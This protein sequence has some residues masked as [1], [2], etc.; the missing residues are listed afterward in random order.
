MSE[1]HALLADTAD[2]VLAGLSGEFAADWRA[3][4]DAG[5]AAVMVPEHLG[6]FGGGFEDAHI[7][8]HAA[9]RHA[10]PLPIAEAILAARLLAESGLASEGSLT[11]AKDAEGRLEDSRFTGTLS[12][13][14]CG[15]DCARAVAIIDGQVISL[16]CGEA[17][18]IERHCDPADTPYLTLRFA[19]APADAAQTAW[20]AHRLFYAM[21]LARAAQIGGAIAAALELAATHVNLREQFGRPLAKFQAIQQ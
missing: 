9:G 21:A 2:K 10:A 1:Q 15:E 7:I 16:A 3:V 4:A 17:E 5:L 20:T 19:G 11:L 14:A 18:V 13:V 12:G 6:G 8:L